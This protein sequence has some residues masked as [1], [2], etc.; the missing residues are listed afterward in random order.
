M[1]LNPGHKRGPGWTPLLNRCK[2]AEEGRGDLP[3]QSKSN[4]DATPK[5]YTEEIHEG[6][7]Q[8]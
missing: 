4:K 5:I 8:Q 2:S 1:D 3:G 7:R 6:Q